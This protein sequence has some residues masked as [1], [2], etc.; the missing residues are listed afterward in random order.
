MTMVRIQQLVELEE[1]LEYRTL[2]S[3]ERKA[4]I[5]QM[6][7]DRLQGAQQTVE[8]VQAL[9]T[10]RSLALKPQEDV[11]TWLK[12]ASLC[13]KNQRLRQ[14]Y[15]TLCCLLD[16]DPLTGNGVQSI[17]PKM[18]SARLAYFKHLW[19]A[20][21]HTSALNGIRELV[22]TIRVRHTRAEGVSDSD[23]GD[24]N[25]TCNKRVYVYV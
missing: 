3:V 13:R 19:A 25:I 5:R 2:Q 12:F 16:Y 9:L 10:V 4:L 17:D 22:S 23:S 6:W 8:V 1:A 15:R 24:R 20:E 11:E 14:S 18:R 21:E 7:N